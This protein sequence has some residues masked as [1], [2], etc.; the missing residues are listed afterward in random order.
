MKEA[1][2][3]LWE[4]SY[5][6]AAQKNWEGL[7]SWMMH[8][9]IEEMKKAAKTVRN[10][11]WGIMN[12]IRLKASNGMVEGKNNCIQRIK[13]IACGFRNKNR[14]MTSILLHFMM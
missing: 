4:Y 10:Y 6:G 7:L 9:R 11:F 2:G 5:P 12:V 13:R 14:F 3:T 8:S 1:D